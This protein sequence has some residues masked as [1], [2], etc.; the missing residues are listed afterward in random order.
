MKTT[1]KLSLTDLHKRLSDKSALYCVSAFAP[2]PGDK[3][4]AKRP[5]LFTEAE[6][7][8][9]KA[10][11]ING[12]GRVITRL[13]GWLISYQISPDEVVLEADIDPAD[14]YFVDITINQSVEAYVFSQAYASYS[15]LMS[16]RFEDFS[17]EALDALL[18]Y[19]AL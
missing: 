3:T 6:L 18:C 11:Y 8:L 17:K 2:S 9:L 5:P 13:K 12:I 14:L 7:P 15:R 1:I 19:L 16:A 4:H 10:F